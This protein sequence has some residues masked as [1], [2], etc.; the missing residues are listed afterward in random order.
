M[1]CTLNVVLLKFVT[2]D[3]QHD[4]KLMKAIEAEV[5]KQFEKFECKENEVLS[6]ITKVRSLFNS[7][8]N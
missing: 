3:W 8:S 2:F 6:D 4:G 1:C 5:G 7:V